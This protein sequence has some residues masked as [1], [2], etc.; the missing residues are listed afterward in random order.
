[1]RDQAAHPH[2]LPTTRVVETCKVLLCGEARRRVNHYSTLAP[3]QRSEP[4]ILQENCAM[5]SAEG[6]AIWDE[7]VKSRWIEP[8]SR[9]VEGRVLPQP[10]QDGLPLP[11][12]EAIK[13]DV[14]RVIDG[15]AGS[16]LPVQLQA[17]F[18]ARTEIREGWLQLTR[19]FE[20]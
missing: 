11:G 15:A 17:A 14:R 5:P 10:G 12:F 6:A 19:E 20:S 8:D 16:I 18:A 1:M 2:P 7:L 13:L 9:G 4:V 3:T